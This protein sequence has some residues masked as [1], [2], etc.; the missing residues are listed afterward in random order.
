MAVDPVQIE[1]PIDD[2]DLD[3]VYAKSGL[4]IPSWD[5]DAAPAIKRAL[6]LGAEA[7]VKRQRV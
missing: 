6:L 4:E 5:S 7:V 2:D 3:A 1:V